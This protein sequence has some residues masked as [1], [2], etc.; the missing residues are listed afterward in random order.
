MA[1][2]KIYEGKTKKLYETD[3]EDE[4]VIEFKND[5]PCLDEENNI[6]I[7]NKG[8]INNSISCHLF[9]YLSSYHITTHF[10]RQ[11]S[12]KE[13]LVKKLEM[14]PLQ[15]ITRNIASGN[16]VKRYGLEEGKELECP[17]IEFYLKSVQVE[18][19]LI[20]K[21][22]IVA[23]GHASSDELK[24]IHRTSF[25]VNVIL[26]DFFRRRK[27]R[28]IDFKLEF[29]RLDDRIVVGDELGFDNFTFLDLETNKKLSVESLRGEKEE[30][31]K[32]YQKINELVM[33]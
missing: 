8:A 3:N 18:D 31:C 33:Q 24:E 25:K 20:N 9:R 17:V 5:V 6:T 29:G 4:L 23:F 7:R 16:L 22:H 21:D 26:E 12:N 30:M 15:V 19:P 2:K 13:M 10:I 11:I 27:L 14:I 28:V 1:K 32:I